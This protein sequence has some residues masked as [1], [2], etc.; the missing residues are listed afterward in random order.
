MEDG[1]MSKEEKTMGML[2]HLAGLA[3]CVVPVVGNIVGPLVVWLLK[4]DTMPFVEEQGRE[5]LNFQITLS[6]AWAIGFVLTFVFIG[7]FVLMAL[8]VVNLVF[9]II[10]AIKANDGISYRYPFALRIL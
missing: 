6:I 5:A 3:G 7:I 10:A 2:C 1:M 4:K 9:A 8:Y